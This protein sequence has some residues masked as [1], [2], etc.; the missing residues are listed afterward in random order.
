[1]ANNRRSRRKRKRGTQT[2]AQTQSECAVADP[3]KN[4]ALDSDASNDQTHAADDQTTAATESE[5][6]PADSAAEASETNDASEVL[7][8][9]IVG[10]EEQLATKDELVTALTER[11]E[12]AVEELDR[13]QQAESQAEFVVDSSDA[14]S[15]KILDEQRKLGELVKQATQQWKSADISPVLQSLGVQLDEIREMIRSTATA[16]S[17]PVAEVADAAAAS[18]AATSR[19]A[20][21]PAESEAP[22]DTWEDLKARYFTDDEDESIQDETEAEPEPVGE[23]VV[24]AELP[25]VDI[26]PVDPPPAIDFDS[27]EPDQLQQA[28]DDRD[29]YISYVLKKLRNA[30]ATMCMPVDWDVIQNAP[31]ELRTR[32]EDLEQQLNDNMKLAE[33]DL[34]LERAR[35]G[36]E[37]ARLA[38][39][40]DQVE[41]K[42]KQVGLSSNDES[43]ETSNGKQTNRWLRFL[44]HAK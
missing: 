31:E 12:Q 15:A 19:D 22:D 9:R 6:Q 13:L 17:W 33:V 27:A 4:A 43:Q 35:L 8:K 20:E 32:L 41:R 24:A 2:N 34:S 10:L 5:K 11:L 25:T 39:Q 18:I 7:D 28:I 3:V 40:A 16:S 1:M 23:S 44:N 29:A 21:P 38:Q 26:E 30:G 14:H 37:E 42:L 36:R